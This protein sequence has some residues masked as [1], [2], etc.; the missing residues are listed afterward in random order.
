MSPTLSHKGVFLLSLVT[1]LFAITQFAYAAPPST[2]YAPGETLT[3]TCA[4]G[5]SNCTVRASAAT[6]ANTDISSLTG[7]TTALSALQGGTGIS[8]YNPGDL[9]YA[10]AATVL[11]RLAS[12]TGGTFLQTSFL[13]GKPSW[14]ATSSLG[15][16]LSDTTG[17]LGSTRGG[18]GLIAAPGYG[19]IPVGNNSGGY[20][21][22]ATSSLGLLGGGSGTVNSGTLNQLAY[23]AANGTTLSSIATSGLGIAL[24][25]TTGTLGVNRGGSGATTFGQGWLYSSGG[26]NAL[27]A[28]T[29]P[30]V[31][32]IVATSTTATSTFANGINLTGGCISFAGTCL[33]LGSGAS[34]VVANAWSALQQFSAGASSTQQS[35]FGKAYFGGTATSSFDSAGVLSLV[36]PLALGSG[37]TATT[38]FAAGGAL[39]SDGSKLTQDVSNFFWDNSSKRLGIAT[40][41]PSNALEVNGVIAGLHLKGVGGTPSVSA[42]A[43]AGSSPTIS[44]RGTDIAGEITLTTGTLPTLSAT[45]LTLTFASAYGSTPF[46]SVVPANAVTA[47]LSGATMVFPTISTGA[48]SLT[49]G[50]TA[51]TA[52]TTYKWDY[53]VIQ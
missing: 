45:V 31:N 23:Y 21:L 36:S 9:L 41:S 42:G 47:L 17:S 20:T 24:S 32:Y 49:S 33:P 51:L 35:V 10:S 29:S 16:A 12:S 18:T 37:G 27:V 13:T 53:I 2:T 5:S 52:A 6:G 22:T 50:L 14:V 26:S 1:G 34:L 39:F 25:D 7:L 11:S 4:P 3:P 30:T 8:S 40:S 19:Q 15:I 38:S 28:S 43:G 44:V 46:I 48:L